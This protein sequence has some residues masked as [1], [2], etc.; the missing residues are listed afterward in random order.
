MTEIRTTKIQ[1]RHGNLSDLPILDVAEFGY[2]VDEYRLF[3]GNPELVIGSGTGTRTVFTLPVIGN[4]PASFD[5]FELVKFYVNG[6]ERNDVVIGMGTV[7][8]GT[9]PANG[10]TVSMKFNSE[11]EVIN[12]AIVPNRLVLAANNPTEDL[13]TGFSFNSAIYDAVFID[14]TIKLANGAGYSIGNIRIAVD[15]QAKTFRLD[16]QYNRLTSEVDIDFSGEFDG[17][18]F[19]L[20]YRN[21]MLETAEFRYTFKIWKM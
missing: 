14:Y 11:I 6:N 2:A 21:K 1:L 5:G 19:K 13:P 15:N 18:V 8:F 3:A 20:T 9:A 4:A 12:T 16:D 7:T 10:A 17:D